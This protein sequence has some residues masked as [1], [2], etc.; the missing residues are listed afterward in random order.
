[1]SDRHYEV[2]LATRDG[3]RTLSAHAER[4]VA[5]MAESVMRRYGDEPFGIGF[6][7]SS[8]DRDASLRIAQYLSTLAFE[9]DPA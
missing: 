6:S 3:R 4:E 5:L 9:V 8:P 1:M 7:V 2:R